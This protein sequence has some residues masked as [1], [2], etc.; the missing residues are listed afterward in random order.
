VP[1]TVAAKKLVAPAL[2]K[3]TVV[4]TL[5]QWLAAWS[6]EDLDA[7]AAFYAENFHSDGMNKK[8][9]VKRKRVL[10]KKYEV[11]SVSGSKFKVKEDKD[12]CYVSFSQK[13]ES[14]GLS[15][16]GIKSLKLVKKGGLWKIYQE[17]WKRK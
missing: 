1:L 8:A 11:I 5:K 10:A 6:S 12:F 2:T 9:W 15:N 14:S 16:R 17:S 7:Y 13:Y 3:E 4:E